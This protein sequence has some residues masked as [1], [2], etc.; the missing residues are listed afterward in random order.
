MRSLDIAL[1]A[2]LPYVAVG[3]ALV[4]SIH[5][6]LVHPYSVSSLSA[7]FLENRKHFW[8]SVPFH[9]GILVVL[10]G[11]LVAFLLPSSIVAW[12]RHPYRLYALE[13]SGLAFALLAL[14]GLANIFLRRATDPRNRVV[15][16][17]ADRILVVLLFLQILSGIEIAVLHGWGS[18]WFVSSATPYLWSVVRFSPEVEYLA[19]M[20]WIVKFHIALA[21]VLVGLVPFTRLVHFLVVP[22]P[23]LW[24]APQVVRWYGWRGAHARKET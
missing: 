9:Y 5:R 6:Y 24:R 19:P 8:G 21:W 17:R 11:H 14:F 18:A 20:P 10:A 23:Y 4:G 3:L 2:V 1:F 16:T 13:V 22:I 12:N 15:T 7:Q